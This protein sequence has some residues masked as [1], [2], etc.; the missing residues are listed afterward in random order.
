MG[1]MRPRIL[2]LLLFLAPGAPVLA[3]QSLE[4]RVDKGI[5]RGVEFLL[6]RYNKRIG[7]GGARGTGTYG[8]GLALPHRV[9][10]YPSG[11]T[12]F[13]LFALLKAGVEPDHKVIKRGFSFLRA[14]HRLPGVA[15]EQSVLLLA[16]A[17]WAGAKRSPDY[18]KGKRRRQRTTSLYNP[19]PGSPLLKT[20]WTWMCRLAG[21]LIQ[22]QYKTGGWRYYP[23]DYNAGG[24]TDVS[25]TQFAV[26]ALSTASRLGYDVPPEVFERARNFLISQQTADGPRVPRAVHMPGTPKDAK[27]RARG[28]PYIA[29]AKILPYRYTT[30][31]MTAAGCASMLIIREE[32]AYKGKDETLDQ[33]IL[34]AFAWLGRNFKVDRNPGYFRGRPGS[35]AFCWLYALERSG[36][37]MGREVIGG[38]SWFGEGA[39]YLLKL[40]RKDGA[41]V[42]TTC[43]KPQDVLGTAFA[44]LFLSRASRPVSGG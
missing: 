25:S 24:P 3:Q 17:E 14:R 9:Y 40:Q 36:D 29:R 44:L 38:H 42:D 12:A 7:W 15:Y 33:G 26:L 18:R 20:R 28:F 1:R 32:L 11:P 30:G 10:G 27:D 16:V 22:Y 4:A 37:L 2:W 23:N 21:R 34:D 8:G 35:Y 31:G 43:M 13:C 6:S 41:F 5:E 39:N 19:P